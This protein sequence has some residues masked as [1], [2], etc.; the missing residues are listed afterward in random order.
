MEDKPPNPNPPGKR[1]GDPVMPNFDIQKVLR[2]PHYDQRPIYD[3]SLYKDEPAK[4]YGFT[5]AVKQRMIRDQ[6]I[7]AQA[8]AKQKAKERLKKQQYYK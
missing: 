6:Q 1:T 8:K 2:L 3:A 7:V 5:E 4:P